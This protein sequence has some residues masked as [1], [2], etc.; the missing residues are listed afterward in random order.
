MKLEKRNRKMLFT[1]LP[2]GNIYTTIAQ[3]FIQKNDIN[4]L[5]KLYQ[6]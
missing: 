3:F 5:T 2:D 4:P 6:L 1:V